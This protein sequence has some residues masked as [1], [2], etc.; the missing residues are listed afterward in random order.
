[1]A[2]KKQGGDAPKTPVQFRVGTVDEQV[3]MAFNHPI[4]NLVM[5]PD[6]ARKLGQA[7]IR[8]SRK[9]QNEKFK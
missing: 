4:E 2:S 5:Y 3:V 7:L 1:M 6:N 8:E 9:I